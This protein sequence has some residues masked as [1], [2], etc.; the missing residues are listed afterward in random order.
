MHTQETA[1]RRM[2]E[3]SRILLD[4]QHE[5]YVLGRPSMSDKE[6]DTLM[7]E[8]AALEAAHPDVK[9]ADS[10]TQR[11]GSDLTSDFPE[12]RHSI[13]V[14]SLD[15]AY[16][17]EAIVSWM[18]KA[19]LKA[20]TGL[21]FIV[22]EKID[23]VSMVLYYEKGILV[24]AVT[25]GNGTVGN[26]VTANIR[27]I[28]AVP[29]RLS[30]PLDIA[31]RGEVY[32]PKESFSVLNKTM[33]IPYANP[34]NLAAGTIRRIKSSETARVPLTIFVY[35]AYFA[36]DATLYPNHVELLAALVRLGFRVN[37]H[38][39]VFASGRQE[40]EALLSASGVQGFSGAFD[41]LA[42]YISGV[43]RERGNLPYEIDG[44]VV[45]V[46]DLALRDVFGYTGHHPRWAIAYKFESPAAQTV[47]QDIDVQVGRTGRI[48]PMA[49]VRSVPIGGSVVSN[50]T[51]H[52]Q[53]YIDLLELAIGDTV[54]V[55]KRGDVIPAVERVV[56]KNEEGNTTWRIPAICP[57]CGSTLVIRGAHTFCP[58]AS[59][60]P[61]QVGGRIQFFV[62]KDGMDIANFG[63]E[64]VTV[65]RN[66]NAL[67][68]IPD[69]YTLDYRRVLDGQPGFGKKKIS[70][71]VTGVEDS[72][73][74]P[75]R[76]VLSALG[77]PDFGRKAVDQLLDA[78]SIRSMEQLLHIVDTH[79]M[80]TLT[81]IPQIG[82][83]M[84]M[85]LIESLSAPEMRARIHALGE[86]GLSFEEEA[87]QVSDV[88]QIFAGQTWCVTGSFE[89]FSPR[90]K[91]MVEVKKRGGRV[92]S[93][94]TGK[95]THLLAGGGAGSKLSQA[96]K[97]G[98]RIVS[99][100]EF[101]GMLDADAKENIR[102]NAGKD[103]NEDS[104]IETQ[105]RLF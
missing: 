91:A 77:L 12:V 65:L 99:E 92:T 3:L 30:E 104:E 102:E 48:T 45:K 94:V 71:I 90:E 39:G 16:S 19:G 78:G 64:T 35:E 101:L 14:L 25:R 98:A 41:D 29:L 83:K 58:N 36:G 55:S 88:P 82:E 17:A 11:V 20:D 74:R 86:A 51:L 44:L 37:P 6:Y 69:I 97:A 28:A 60:C 40:A 54:E 24:R 70:L 15:K 56:E 105:G 96:Q 13:P 81:S 7:D 85:T 50:V 8:L 31:V 22:E 46:N 61:A 63:P 59:G 42:G 9:E 67:S 33:E 79:D 43:T 32:L 103:A 49:R 10:P 62:G 89:H 84:A 57:S 100:D 47:V 5:Y 95:T 26:D 1:V 52:N 76:V 93:S 21:S 38:L 72:R 75:F 2:A 66:I 34:R 87:S 53:D 27:T 18:N 4:A 68:D 23:G 80:D 73:N